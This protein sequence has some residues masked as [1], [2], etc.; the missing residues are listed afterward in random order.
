MLKVILI[1]F[2]IVI[3]LMILPLS[4][5]ENTHIKI[6][7]QLTELQK[8]PN[9][10]GTKTNPDARAR[11]EWMRL[12][13]P[14]SNIIP[15]NI[16][17]KEIAFASKIPSKENYAAVLR[18]SGNLNN[19]NVFDWQPRGPYNIGGR[20]R[21]LAI[22]VTN[23]NVILA[24]GVSGGMWRSTDGGESWTKTTTPSQLHSVTCI[25]Q[26]TRP[27][28]T[29]IWYYG[30]GEFRG[31]TTRF[32]LLGDGI[33]KS[34]DGGRTW[35]NLPS[36]SS[37]TPHIYDAFD[38]VLN[39][40]TDP[41]NKEEDV[42]YAA[43]WHGIYRSNDGGTTW[44]GVL[45][46]PFSS[47]RPSFYSDIALVPL[48]SNNLNKNTSSHHTESRNSS[49]P[50]EISQNKAVTISVDSIKN[51]Q[52]DQDALTIVAPAPNLTFYTGEGSVNTYS[53]DET[54]DMLTIT[55][56]IQNDGSSSAH[57]VVMDWYL[58][59]DT[60]IDIYLLGTVIQD[61]LD[62]GFFRNKTLSVTLSDINELPEGT[63]YIGAVI[64][65]FDFVEELDETDNIITFD[66]PITYLAP[67]G[68]VIIAALSDDGEKKG[69]WRSANGIDWTNITP[70]NWPDVY[71]RNVI[72]IAPSNENVVYLL[73]ETPG[74]GYYNETDDTWHSL[75]K[76]TYVSGNGS[77][78][79]GIWENRSDN[80]PQFGGQAGDFDSQRGYDLLIKV[81]PDDENV[82]FIGGTNLYRSTDGFASNTN[83]A[84]IG[85]YSTANDF[86]LYDNHFPDQHALAFYPS[87]SQS[88]VSGHDGG[89]S[90]TGNNLASDVS[91]TFLNNGYITT[92]F[93]TV[94]VDQN[95]PG[96]PIIMG[97]MQD[98]GT[99][100]IN[101]LGDKWE[102]EIDGGD[103]SFA[104]VDGT[105]NSLYTSLQ[106]GNIT[107]QVYNED[108]TTIAAARV[109]PIG[110]QHYLFINPFVLDPNNLN[111]MY[112]AEG[113]RI[114]RNSDLTGI[115]LITKERLLE[116]PPPP[117]EKTNVNW[118][119]L[120]NAAI[121]GSV[122]T[123]LGVTTLPS[124]R[125]YYG[126]HRGKIYRL[127]GANLGNP[128]PSEVT[129]GSFTPG[130]YVSCLAVD[131]DD[132]DRVMAV[133]SNYEVKSLFYTTDGGVSWTDVSGNLEE[134]S[135]GTGNGPSTRWAVI[136]PTR[137]ITDY[138]VGTSTGLY[139]T[140]QLNGA[141][142]LWVQEG[143]STIG[144]VIVSMIDNRP[145][146][147]LLVV[148]TH[149]NG[150]YSG[151]TKQGE[152]ITSVEEETIPGN[153]TL[154]QNYPNPFNPTTTIAYTLAKPSRV[155]IRIYNI[156]GQRV[157][158]YDQS[159][160]PSGTFNV[161]WSGVNDNG[162]RVASGTY[163][164]RLEAVTSNGENTVLTKK[165]TLLK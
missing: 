30:T 155:E 110:G 16:R 48:L 165:M 144:N 120:T 116:F 151:Y 50:I 2:Y 142:T 102:K 17:S 43:T 45:G 88:M 125:V 40:V 8:V 68:S 137:G 127:D 80:V 159:M 119:V 37:N 139:S 44:Q 87:N 81:K 121:S 91:W 134:H 31:S 19:S 101:K 118:A 94:A 21:A 71:N 52:T 140:R 157:K 156:V 26:D 124:D 5:I 23:E 75:W 158:T 14:Q 3:S 113:D 18:K 41:T 99:A 74:F 109:D 63:Y 93:Y 108:H 145:S 114:W 35:F 95:S 163:I 47:S 148:A 122:I 135:D 126:T 160:Q 111:I 55:S 58:F 7:Q 66:E 9:T 128:L 86:S 51:S 132:G 27:G 76:Y 57:N 38:R 133:F 56:S 36:T 138:F 98:N 136:H 147:G 84:W 24:G 83:T 79:G 130:A 149:G 96:D 25:A 29:N 90:R 62:N 11:Y 73:A 115:P 92:Q 154:H 97:G 28:K 60:N 131:P 59:G 77:G 141:N 33:F 162:S 78:S 129:S 152:I 61:S 42:V 39:V 13:N 161:Q 85:G 123:A 117:F 15:Q 143:I 100:R 153:F 53:Y 69:I 103:G 70:S 32:G 1:S 6:D 150:V 65:P 89:I 4:D 105:R 112:V 104:A 164:I 46:N 107:R 82:V 20:T 12:R 146:D 54:S 106:Y 72:G 10:I 64:D 34:T 49:I 67:G 22:D